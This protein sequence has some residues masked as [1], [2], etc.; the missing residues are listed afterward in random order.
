MG[1]A[2]G[3]VLAAVVPSMPR[4]IKLP[5]YRLRV[6]EIRVYYDIGEDYVMIHGIIPKERTFEWLDEHGIPN[7]HSTPEPS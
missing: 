2:L 4:L 5:Q 7:D 3:T 1:T 6:D